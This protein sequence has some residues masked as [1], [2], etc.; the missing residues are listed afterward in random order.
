MPGLSG[1]PRPDGRKGIRNHLVVAYLVECAHHVAREI[2]LPFREQGV[3][4]IGFPGCYPN[5]Y[6]LAMMERLATHP[7]V[8]GALLVSLGCEGFDKRQL[9]Q[10]HRSVGPAGADDRHP[11]DRAARRSRSPPG[12]TGS[13]RRCPRSRRSRASRCVWTS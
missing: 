6:A 3:H 9:A 8:G 5:A 7:N 1:F 12:A 4:L 2:V 11:A 10:H 13:K